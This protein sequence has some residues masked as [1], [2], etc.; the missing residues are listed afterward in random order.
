MYRDDR[1]YHKERRRAQ[2][3]AWEKRK[4]ERVIQKKREDA[5]KRL[6][7]RV[8]ERIQERLKSG[9]LQRRPAGADSSQKP[10]VKRRMEEEPMPSSSRAGSK[11][12]LTSTR[13]VAIT[14]ISPAHVVRGKFLG[15]GSYV[16]C[17]LGQYRGFTV[18]VKELK[19]HG[20]PR[21][22]Q[23]K[24][25][26]RVRQE[27][28]R[29]AKIVRSLGDHP[30]LP[31]LFG[32]SSLTQPFRL[33][34]QFHGEDGSSTTIDKAVAKGIIPDRKPWMAILLKVCCALGHVHNNGYLHNDLKANNVVLEK[35][36]DSQYAPVLIDFGKSRPVT[37]P[38]PP[39]VLSEQQQRDYRKHYSHIAPEI[40]KG[41]RAQSYASDVYSFA[42]M[43]ITVSKKVVNFGKVPVSVLQGKKENPGDRPT[44]NELIRILTECM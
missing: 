18:V 9:E 26:K 39:K 8:E 22:V 41:E 27:L 30:G 1:R 4:K 14:E 24:T 7:Q 3:K 5:K 20:Q 2:K 38:K 29:E 11:K 6:E 42:V 31:L 28:L 35:R 43:A 12:R 23:E 15:S 37:D 44:I 34:L 25:E 13:E 17:Y 10:A 16:S 21:E 32:V 36:G 33:I 40:V 19:V